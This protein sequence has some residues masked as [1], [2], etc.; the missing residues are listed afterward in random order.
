MLIICWVLYLWKLILKWI[1]RKR[2]FEWSVSFHK[3]Y[4]ISHV[5]FLI[6]R[7]LESDTYQN[8]RHVLFDTQHSLIAQELHVKG[9]KVNLTSVYRQPLSD[10][11]NYK[12]A[13]LY[14]SPFLILLYKLYIILL[15]HKFTFNYSEYF[16]SLD[17]HMTYMTFKL[18]G[19]AALGR[20]IYVGSL[21]MHS[22]L[23]DIPNIS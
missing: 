14:V 7:I 1:Q 10:D 6:Y 9:E 17:K 15:F 16:L 4:L 19:K 8:Y 21:K 12:S 5:F 3:C 13:N 2:K 11:I 23:K 22:A 20:E 18:A